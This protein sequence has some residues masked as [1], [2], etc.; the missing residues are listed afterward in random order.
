MQPTMWLKNSE[1]E[2]WNL[3]PQNIQGLYSSYF[4]KVS[5]L[6]LKTKRTYSR[7]N[8]DF[9]KT[10]TEPQQVD[11]SGTMIFVS[12][13]QKSNFNSFVGDF[14]KDLRFYYDPE[15][16][17]DP[18]SQISRPWYKTVN[19]A[20]MDSEEQ[21]AIGTFECKTT[22]T[23]LCATWRRDRVVVSTISTPIGD[24]HVIPFVYP[25]FYQSERKLYLNIL[26]EGEKI[27]CRIEIKN[28]NSEALT[29]L[30]WVCTSGTHRQYAKWLAGY[31]LAAGRTLVI[32]STPMSQESTIQNNGSSEDIQ[33]YQEPNPQFINFIELHPGNNQIVFNFG[34]VTGVDISVSYAEETRLL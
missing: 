4:N 8:N 3:R 5:G 10:K 26:N 18:R 15:G 17:I 33:D 19:V 16:R 30:E 12:P 22:F 11:I 6:G 34:T 27:G 31:G 7:N 24:P 13:R 2:I 9:V 1:G 29:K 20:Q 21:T 28:N 32:D 14:S 23:P 25:Y